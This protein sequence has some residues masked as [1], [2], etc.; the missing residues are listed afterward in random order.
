MVEGLIKNRIT[1]A[2]NVNI[3]TS[4]V[5]LNILITLMPLANN[6]LQCQSLDTWLIQC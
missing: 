6:N 4:A 3:Q 2:T 5:N 1:T